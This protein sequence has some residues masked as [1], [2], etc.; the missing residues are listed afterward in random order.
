MSDAQLSAGWDCGTK[1]KP[2]IAEYMSYRLFVEECEEGV[3]YV[4]HTPHTGAAHS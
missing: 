2:G 1:E 3:Q 4:T